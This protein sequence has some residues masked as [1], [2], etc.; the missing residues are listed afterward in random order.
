M[1]FKTIRQTVAMPACPVGES[2][3]RR[4]VKNGEVPGIYSGKRFLVNTEAFF[5]QIEAKSL[6]SVHAK[7]GVK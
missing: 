2:V 7:E 4:M 6:A 5:P 3:L 1:R